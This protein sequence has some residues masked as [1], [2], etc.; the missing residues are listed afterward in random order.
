MSKTGLF[1][2]NNNRRRWVGWTEEWFHSVWMNTKEPKHLL[3]D[4][5]NTG[6]RA[7]HPP[8]SL[9]NPAPVVALSNRAEHPVPV[10]PAL[11]S[12]IAP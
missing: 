11:K 7:P 12:S 1:C 9:V 4:I 8:L 3:V 5:I 10:Q 2:P 6:E